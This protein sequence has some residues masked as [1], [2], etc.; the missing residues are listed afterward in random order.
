ML[1]AIRSR[2]GS[3]IVKILFAFLILSFAVWGIGDIFRDQP[4][5]RTVAEVADTEISIEALDRAF[6]G[7]LS[8]LQQVLGPQ[9][10]AQT[11]ISMGVLDQALRGLVVDAL[12][13]AYSQEIGLSAPNDLV[14]EQVRRQPVFEDPVTGQFDRERFLAILGRSGLSEA[15]YIDLLRRD[16]A[17]QWIAGSFQRAAEAPDVLAEALFRHRRETRQAAV[18]RFAAADRG[19]V[20]QP[21][22][23]DLAAFH[24]A[25]P[26]RFTAPEYRT[27]TVVS[28]TAEEMAAEIAIDENR[29]RDE[30]ESRRGFFDSPERRAFRQVVVQDRETAEAIAEAARGGTDL[31]AAV[32]RVGASAEVIPLDLGPRDSLPF[33]EMA[34]AGFALEP[35][36]VS[37]PVETPFGWHVM[38]VTEIVE[39]GTQSFEQ[40][41]ERIEQDLKQERALDAV[42]E[43]ANQ[44]EDALAGGASL[45]EAADSLGLP[46]TTTPPMARDG[47]VR[48][49]APA[50]DL[51]ARDLVLST[52]FAEDPG[53]PSRLTETDRGDFFILRVDQ[54]IEPQVRPLDEVRDAVAEAWRAERRQERAAELAAQAVER[55][56]LGADPADVA[57][58]LG[59]TASTP[60]ALRRDGSPAGEASADPVDLPPAGVTALFEMARSEAR[61][62]D[63]P[64]G[65]IAM[66]LETITTPEPSAEA[67][68]YEQVAAGVSG[69]LGQDLEQQFVEALRA[70]YGVTINQ[71]AIQDYYDR[72]G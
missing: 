35:D 56:A 39:G 3:W 11:A 19:P 36:G 6:R 43:M 5:G 34:Q 59:G 31:A 46:V 42:F 12:Y 18:V 8:R 17:R 38:A 24:E 33:D 22:P 53:V 64:D 28:L 51:P 49:D 4:Q 70:R 68:A 1:Q 61:A 47:S 54:V 66:R 41:R 9:L 2:V 20:A 21:T 29:L 23:Q 7:E 62:I 30:Y 25:N 60:P 15:G 65:H 52:A 37:A 67:E 57:A 63:T 10:D 40:V 27:M 14:A 16:L 50:P 72:A 55:L 26:D 32:D 71:T 13:A 48:G 58:D 69:S 45:E 44:L